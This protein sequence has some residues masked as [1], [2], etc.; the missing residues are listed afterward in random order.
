VFSLID[1]Y[2]TLYNEWG[3]SEIDRYGK[4]ATINLYGPPG[5]GKT[6]CAEAIAKYFRRDII[7]I[8]YAEIES[9]YVGDTPKN[10]NA[11][12]KHAH[13]TKAILLFDEAD[14]ILGRR[15]T[16]VTQ[17]A[18]HSV[19]ISRAVMLHQLDVFG[20]I[21]IFCTNLAKNYDPAFV[22][23]IFFHLNF[24]EPD[25]KTRCEIWDK[26]L[27]ARLPGST[28]LDRSTLSHL[29][30]GL[31]GGDIKNIVINASASAVCRHGKKQKITLEDIKLATELVWQAK[32]DVGH[33]NV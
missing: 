19:N 20:G 28:Q 27:P 24:T 18:D 21:V 7:E 16:D 22:R 33:S 2:D 32:K 5:T 29:T 12:F 31:V 3:I 26:M 14:S 6:T 10:I 15:M 1:H 25:Y 9:K 11:A 4:R 8:N 17:S 23:R 13:R 30:D